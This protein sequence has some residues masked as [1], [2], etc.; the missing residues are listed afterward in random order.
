MWSTCGSILLRV[1]VTFKLLSAPVPF[2]IS[3]LLFVHSCAPSNS[4]QNT[5]PK[6]C[7]WCRFF[8][9]VERAPF[10]GHFEF[11]LQRG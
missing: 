4:V 10:G 2:E 8:L 1:R 7:R 6:S 5:C 11:V 9:N 3:Y